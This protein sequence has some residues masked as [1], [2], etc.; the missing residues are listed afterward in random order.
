MEERDL[1]AGVIAP[2]AIISCSAAF[3]PSVSI[4]SDWGP[5]GVPKGG[6]ERPAAEAEDVACECECRRWERSVAGVSPG[7]GEA[8]F[9]ADS[10]RNLRKAGD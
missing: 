10:R 3:S 5:E 1:A 7:C 6:S 2:P 4:A 8:D 9:P